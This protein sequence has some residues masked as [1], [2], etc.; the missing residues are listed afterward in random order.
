MAAAT[1]RTFRTHWTTQISHHD[2]GL[3]IQRGTHFINVDVYSRLRL[4]RQR[5]TLGAI[6]LLGA[7]LQF[8]KRITR[9]RHEMR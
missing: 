3:E 9:T 8:G 6:S 4:G 7:L 2:R 1:M 5:D